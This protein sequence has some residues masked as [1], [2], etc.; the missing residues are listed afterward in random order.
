MKKTIAMIMSVGLM[1]GVANADVLAAWDFDGGTGAEVSVAAGTVISPGIETPVLIL[2]GDGVNASN[3]AGRFN[4]NNW[5]ETSLAEAIAANDYFTWSLTASENYTLS[6]SS[7]DFNFQRSN[8][9]GADWALRSSVDSFGSDLASF[10]GLANGT[11]ESIDLSAA[12]LDGLSSIEFRFYGYNRT[13][14][15]GTAG[16]EG[17]GDDLVVNGT[18]T[19]VPEPASIALIGA[20]LA[21]VSGFRRRLKA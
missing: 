20:G 6:I 7:I 1:A 16:F 19:V 8:T 10:T 3:N 15:A 17:T 21:L 4:A 11:S 18:V 12:G 5:T 14:T 13:G 9:G 2:R